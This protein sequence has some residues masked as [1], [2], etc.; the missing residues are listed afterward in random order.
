MKIFR[1][2]LALFMITYSGA[3][4]SSAQ[5]LNDYEFPRGDMRVMFYNVENLFDIYD[6]KLKS[7]EEF[8][9]EGV[10]YWS[11][12][13]YHKKLFNI[14]KVIAAL[15][16][17]DLPEVIGVCE[18]ENRTVLEDL[19]KKTALSQFQYRIVHKESPDSRG[20]DVGF[21]Y[22]KDKF[23]PISYEAVPVSF[24]YEDSRSTRDILYVKGITNSNDTLHFFINHWPSRY[25]GQLE[26]DRNREYTAS[27]LRHK[28]DSL[29]AVHLNP[30]VI[31]M[32]DLNDYPVNNS[33][34]NVLKAKTEYDRIQTEE[35]Y[36]LSWYLQEVKGKGTHKY[37][38][39]W[40][41]L[42]QIIVSGELLSSTNRIH[43]S[44]DNAHVFEAPFL[45]EPDQHYTGFI[46]F[47]T[48]VGF[49][50]HDGFSDHL[51]VYLDL[52]FGK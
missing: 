41:V 48:Y 7:D 11:E 36:N 50:F 14:S 31:I 22:R 35:L 25:G 17:W 46:T 20:I 24:P 27:I 40:G 19:I 13:R 2:V 30:N 1:F 15:G 6:D 10:R 47:R 28:V 29:F 51:P 39:K 43:T 18:I 26:S 52:F 5:E 32:G 3:G 37:E 12:D 42:D 23:K 16:Q 9:P 44:I 34:I 49:K 4:S 38:G 33:L 21:L 45:L 8:T